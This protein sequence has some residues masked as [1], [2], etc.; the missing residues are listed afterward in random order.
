MIALDTSAV[1]AI[2]LDE[3]EAETFD[4]AIASGEA[5]IGTPTLLE[6]RL[7]LMQRMPGFAA[8]FLKAFISPAEINSIPFTFDMYQ[9]AAEAFER[10][11]KGRGHPAQ[12]NFG[13]CM[14]YAVAKHYDVPLLY[15]GRGFARTDI[16]PA[17]P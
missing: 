2:A 5:L 15:K 7:V 3:D 16:R 9:S 17:L 14:A 1:V 11:G 13:D 4:R 8:E 12:L 6:T 10:Y